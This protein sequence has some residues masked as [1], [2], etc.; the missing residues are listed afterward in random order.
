M[1]DVEVTY[2]LY[3]T[4]ANDDN[5]PK[6]KFKQ[7]EYQV[8]SIINTQEANGFYID[9]DKAKKLA[10]TL[11]FKK[12]SIE[13]KLAKT[14]KPKLLAKGPVVTPRKEK[15]LLIKIPNNNYR[16]LYKPPYFWK[17]PFKILKNGK[18]RL[19]NLKRFVISMYP[20]RLIRE[21]R[22]GPYQPIHLVKFDPGSRHHIRK[23]LKDDYNI[24]FNTFTDKGTPKIEYEMLITLDIKEGKLLGEYLKIV[25]DLSQLE[26]GTGALL[27]NYREKTSTVTSRIDILGTNT[28][29]FTSSSINLN[30]IPASKEFRELFSTP[31]YDYRV[32]N[33][34]WEQIKPYLKRIE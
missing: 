32:S 15:G 20:I 29:R 23:W 33:E 5:F 26:S 28:G 31:K 7:I 6:E 34:V 10:I 14:F 22:V 1:Q 11:R 25:K 30:Q 12:E 2:Q 9:I 8:Q 17:Q 21:K 4:L 27:K 19:A 13:R 3:K 18:T 16:D 24:E